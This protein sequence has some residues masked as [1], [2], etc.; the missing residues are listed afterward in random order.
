MG[1]YEG[2]LARLG[3]PYIP[4]IGNFVTVDVRPFG[5][6]D[7]PEVFQKLLRRGVIVRPIAN[8]QMPGH[9]RISIGLPEENRRCL[10]ELASVLGLPSPE[11]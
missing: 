1:Y 6:G 11:A 8:Y 3:I 7:G 5:A 4:S 10:T 2:N 9:L